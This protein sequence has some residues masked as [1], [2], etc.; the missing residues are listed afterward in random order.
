M[1]VTPPATRLPARLDQWSP[2]RDIGDLYQQMGRFMQPTPDG[3]PIWSPPADVTETDDTY[4]VEIEVPGVRRDDIDVEIKGNELI[5]SGELKEQERKGLLR[6]KTRRVGE[7]E[8]RV[9]LPGDI[10]DHGVEASLANG[11][12]TVRVPKAEH[13]K[14]TKIKVT[15]H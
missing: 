10:Q 2:L 15:E 12:L 13:A 8:Y 1:T 14:A 3:D 5:V 9:L 7:F 6:R 11:V 4:V